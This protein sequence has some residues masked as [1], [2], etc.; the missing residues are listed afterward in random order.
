MS[1]GGLLAAYLLGSLPFGYVLARLKGVDI[2]SV[3]SGNIGATNV[4]RAL[5][6]SWG[7]LVFL[8]KICIMF[9]CLSILE[10]TGYLS[11]AA[12][13]VDRWLR[14]VGRGA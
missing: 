13:V 10:D 14:R 9:F 3:G 5:G 6:K 2:R 11:R 8:P 4:G 1:A 12:C 7:V